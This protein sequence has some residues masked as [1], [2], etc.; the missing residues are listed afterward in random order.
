MVAACGFSCL[1]PTRCL[2]PAEPPHLPGS[3][4]Q[5]I[6]LGTSTPDCVLIA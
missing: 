2:A 6:S 5:E 1:A 4:L 3:L